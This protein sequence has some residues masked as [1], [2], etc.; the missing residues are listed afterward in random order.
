MTGQINMLHFDSIISN[1]NA[2]TTKQVLQ[3]LSEHTSNLVGTSQKIVYETLTEQ[4]R[5]QSSGIGHGVAI[6]H[7][8]LPRL[9]RPLTIFAKLEKS[10]DFKSVDGEPVDL[11]CL[12]M[13][14][15]HEGP[16]H[17]NRLAAVSR[18]LNDVDLCNRLRGAEDAGNIKTLIKQFNERKL[19]A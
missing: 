15:E 8:R 5:Q 1:M 6:A 10:V 4:E 18:N 3:K 7:M 16:Q 2:T 11:V 17:L 9:T 19:A 14:P 12:V 13:S